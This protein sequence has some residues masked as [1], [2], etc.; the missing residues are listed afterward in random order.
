MFYET[1][2]FLSVLVQISPVSTN[3][4]PVGPIFNLVDSQ[5]M[6]RYNSN[7]FEIGFFEIE[8]FDNFNDPFEFVVSKTLDYD[9]ERSSIISSACQR[10]WGRIVTY[11]KSEV[12]KFWD[13]FAKTG[14]G[15]IEGRTTYLGQP[16]QCTNV[17]SGVMPV[18]VE[19][20]P[21]T[22]P[23]LVAFN[24]NPTDKF[25]FTVGVCLPAECSTS[26]AMT[27][28]QR[29]VNSAKQNPPSVV[30]VMEQ[31]DIETSSTG[32]VV[33][34]VAYSILLILVLV[35]TLLGISREALGESS[36]N[37]IYSVLKLHIW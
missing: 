1:L 18:E 4:L 8:T 28:F 26:D 21:D 32:F 2:A 6:R 36:M 27:I 25:V 22:K 33:A 14:T 37:C 19:D 12:P 10:D 17:K 15:I 20:F 34:W 11:S 35:G 23:F 24:Q 13:S 3:V 31:P 29:L 5:S 30:S 9:F 16:E 7:F